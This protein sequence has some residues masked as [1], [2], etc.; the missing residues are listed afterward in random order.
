MRN[1]S[2]LRIFALLTVLAL[3]MPVLAKPVTKSITLNQPARVGSAQ[4]EAGDY[5]LVI[6]DTKVTVK[7][8]KEV[9]AT[10]EGRWEMRETKASHNSILTGANGE[11]KEVRFGGDKRV[12]VLGS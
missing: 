6:E 4:L 11:I 9:L 10:I 2:L 1:S 8:G 3:A 7:R 12:L 5:R